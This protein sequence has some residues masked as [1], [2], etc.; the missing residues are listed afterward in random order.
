MMPTNSEEETSSIIK[1]NL[2]NNLKAIK[3]LLLRLHA[4]Q[5]TQV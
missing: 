4:L 5:V 3:S 1:L 2:H